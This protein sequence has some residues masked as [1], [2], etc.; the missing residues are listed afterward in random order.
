MEYL[1]TITVLLFALLGIAVQWGIQRADLK[2]VIK[3]M[4]E[5]RAQFEDFHRQHFAHAADLNLHV[6]ERERDAVNTALKEHSARDDATFTRIEQSL[7]EL[8]QD[9]K[10][11]LHELRK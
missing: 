8:R 2:A 7:Q 1:G 5:K 11:V 6:P 10:D 4:Y 9:I 3:D